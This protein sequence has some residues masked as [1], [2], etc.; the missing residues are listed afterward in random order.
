MG[1]WDIKWKQRVNNSNVEL[2]DDGR[3]VDDARAYM[4]P[5]RPGWRWDDGEL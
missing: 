1:R 2:E 3:Y 5:I 4:Y